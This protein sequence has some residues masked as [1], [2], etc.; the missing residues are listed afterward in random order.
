MLISLQ[1]F[2]KKNGWIEVHKTAELYSNPSPNR[3]LLKVH[4]TT[5]QLCLNVLF[6]IGQPNASSSQDPQDAIV[7]SR[8]SH[9]PSHVIAEVSLIQRSGFMMLE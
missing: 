6:V 3:G 5:I 4:Q 2:Y 1:I 7:G 9:T 8:T